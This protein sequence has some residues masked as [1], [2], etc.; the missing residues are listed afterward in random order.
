MTNAEFK[1]KYNLDEDLVILIVKPEVAQ[2]IGL[3]SEDALFW[4]RI[5]TDKYE[6]YTEAIEKVD[7]SA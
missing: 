7:E 3:G 2:K 6:K 1:E 4:D 5:K